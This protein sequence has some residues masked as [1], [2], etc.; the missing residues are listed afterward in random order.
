MMKKFKTQ[1]TSDLKSESKRHK[2]ESK[3]KN[4]NL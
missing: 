1:L 2:R 3:E 4:M